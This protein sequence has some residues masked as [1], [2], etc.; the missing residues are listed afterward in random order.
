M[1]RRTQAIDIHGWITVAGDRA[2][3]TVTAVAH[4]GSSRPAYDVELDI[5]DPQYR[6]ATQV[7]FGMLRPNE[8]RELDIDLSPV[9][10]EWHSEIAF[11][12]GDGRAW[13][14]DADGKLRAETA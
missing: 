3:T 2:V 14:R 6:L 8:T 1:D 13:R 7:T 11:T 10:G 4:N 9:P 12:D 5:L